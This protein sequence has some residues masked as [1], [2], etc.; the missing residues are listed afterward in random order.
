MI[1]TPSRQ[2]KNCK[3]LK[4]F[5]FMKTIFNCT[6]TLAENSQSPPIFLTSYH[7]TAIHYS[8]CHSSLFC[9]G[10]ESFSD[11]AMHI[12]NP[13]SCQH[14]FFLCCS[15]VRPSPWRAANL[16]SHFRWRYHSWGPSHPFMYAHD[17]SMCVFCTGLSQT[18]IPPS[19]VRVGNRKRR[20]R[21]I[22]AC[23]LANRSE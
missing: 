16:H 12:N 23:S 19:R 17:T 7:L 13:K 4:N 18:A 10:E 9:F 5:N 11:A 6:S 1:C 20:G 14:Y 15:Q 2:Y 3:L 8:V 22:L 21:I